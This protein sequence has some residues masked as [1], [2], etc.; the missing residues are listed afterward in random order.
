M[1]TFLG[2]PIGA[3]ALEPP[4][5]PRLGARLRRLGRP[6]PFVMEGGYAVEKIGLHAVGVLSGFEGA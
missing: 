1:D 6:T 4:D 5:Y 2:D 3:F